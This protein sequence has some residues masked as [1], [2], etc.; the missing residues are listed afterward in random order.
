MK[1]ILYPA[2]LLTSVV[3]LMSGCGKISFTPDK[4]YKIHVVKGPSNE[5]TFTAPLAEKKSESLTDLAKRAQLS[6]ATALH[7]DNEVITQLSGVIATASKTWYIYIND[8]KINN[9]RL[10]NITV[11]PSDKIECRYEETN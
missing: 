10:S 5:Q 8:K 6:I 7:G 11:Q 3:I 2:L 1:K 4:E 9:P